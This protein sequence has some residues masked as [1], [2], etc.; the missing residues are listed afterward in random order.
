MPIP[1]YQTLMAPAL[2]CLADGTAKTG[3]EHRDAVAALLGITDEERQETIASGA[4]LFDNRV[5]WSIT[6][7]AQAGTVSRPR[8]G[9]VQITD[10]GQD[11]LRRHPDRVDN[12]ILSTFPEFIEFRARARAHTV[13]DPGTTP[14]AEQVDQSDHTPPQETIS[15]AVKV[16]NSAV[17]DELLNRIRAR[18][19][20]FLERLV[21]RLLTAMGYGGATG[22]AEHLGRSG[23][24]GLDGVIRQDTLGLDRIYVQAK[25]YAADRPIGRPGIQEFVGALHGAQADRGI[26]ITTSRFT[27]DA[28][29]YAERV[30][31]RV[32]LID[33]QQLAD[34][35]IT[36]DVGV[37]IHTTYV[38]K[39][40]DEDFFEDE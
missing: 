13:R 36:H 8:R 21:L 35:M 11:V 25:R 29:D 34:L 38:I 1:D 22:A 5:Q 20:S 2:K 17:A 9:V 12:T 40:V 28:Y 16:A 32:I 39:R 3:R 18:D 26:Y 6:Y 15:N 10:R 4:P 7:L 30:Q 24:E 27:S 31:A 19:P 14:G 33:G 23:D 37:Q